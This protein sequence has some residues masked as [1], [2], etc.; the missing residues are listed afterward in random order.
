MLTKM[1][2]GNTGATDL[3]ANYMRGCTI[4]IHGTTNIKP[5][6]NIFLRGVL[7]NL[8]G[9][10]FVHNVRE[11]I[12]PQSYQTI[13]ECVLIKTY[14]VLKDD[15]NNARVVQDA[16]VSSVDSEDGGDQNQD[17][18]ESVNELDTGS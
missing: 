9:I 4:T 1:Q 2:E 7:P 15:Q 5:F 18:E 10:Y 11:S 6:S 16:D 8:E 12:T 17:V 14:P 13:I 3:L